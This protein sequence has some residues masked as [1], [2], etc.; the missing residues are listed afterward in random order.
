MPGQRTSPVGKGVG[1]E[2][3]KKR[4]STAAPGPYYGYAVVQEARFLLRL[5]D[6]R[7]G[8]HIAIEGLDDVSIEGNGVVTAEQNKSGLAH[9]PVADRSIELWKTF[10]NWLEGFRNGS[11]PPG[12]RLV[13][14]VAQE[15]TGEVIERLASCRST[16]ETVRTIRWLR[17]K[18]WGTAPNYAKRSE[19][20]DALRQYLDPFLGASDDTLSRILNQFLFIKGHGAPYEE[21]AAALKEKTIGEAAV[22]PILET[23]IGWVKRRIAECIEDGKAPVISQEAFQKK[24]LACARKFDRSDKELVSVQLPI[25]DE[26][27]TQQLRSSIYVRQMAIVD[28]ENEHLT[29]AVVE[30]LRASA[31]RAAWSLRGDVLE[32]S[33]DQYQ[34]E[35][36]RAWRRNKSATD[37]AHSGKSEKTIGQ[38]LYLR[39]MELR[40]PLQRMEVPDHFTPGSFHALAD[41]QNIG[42]HPQYSTLLGEQK[43]P[44]GGDVNAE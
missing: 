16:E 39:C 4:R 28:F 29:D 19:C 20:S 13:L 15:H 41:K 33:F 32:E 31:D 36:L 27:V 11:L 26:E 42:W 35:L 34:Q 1:V 2:K 43:G 24:L 40:H 21:V 18:Y 12:T 37:I 6:A 44:D 17:E 38:A 9:N 14:Y 7:P 3:K 30:Y 10:Y 23:L 8:D 25:T 5:L 22:Q